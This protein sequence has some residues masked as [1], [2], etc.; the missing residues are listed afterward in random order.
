M[1]NWN[2]FWSKRTTREKTLNVGG[3]IFNQA[4]ARHISHYIGPP[5]SCGPILEVGTGRGVCS[6]TL[7]KMGYDCIGVDSSEVAVELA[8]KNHLEAMLCD[9]RH[10]PFGPK[11]FEV[12]FTQGL[13]EHI[14]F[15]DQVAILMETQRVARL[16]IH[17]VPAKHGVMDIG[18]RAFKLIGKEWPYPDEKKYDRLEFG[19]L[20]ETT[21]PTVKI[22][23]FLKVDW[24]GYCH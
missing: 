11:T 5:Q 16:V 19:K 18:E 17:S 1:T 23:G 7:K 13:L 4:F 12:A 6:L 20:L 3:I 2:L 9:G 21:F 24:I 8:R 22:A 10:L 15:E 14:A